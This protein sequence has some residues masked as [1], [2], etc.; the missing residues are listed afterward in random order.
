MARSVFC[1]VC[2]ALVMLTGLPAWAA[3]EGAKAAAAPA[4]FVIAGARKVVEASEPIVVRYALSQAASAGEARRIEW[5][6]AGADGRTISQGA[7]EATALPGEFSIPSKSPW[8]LGT[9]KVS[10]TISVKDDGAGA[11]ALEAKAIEEVVKPDGWK[12]A[13]Y[14]RY[15]DEL[16]KKMREKFEPLAFEF[17]ELRDLKNVSA[18]ASALG[19]VGR[20]KLVRE[21]LD[22]DDVAKTARLRRY[23]GFLEFA[24]V[25]P[26]ARRE[27]KADVRGLV[28]GGLVA[29]DFRLEMTT[30]Q[31]LAEKLL[32]VQP[33]I[34]KDMKGQVL[35]P[36]PK[37]SDGLPPIPPPPQ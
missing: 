11:A 34:V 15:L 18:S 6:V 31:W 35:W 30:N 33:E 9:L 26:W 10:A 23:E 27:K 21:K 37:P 29:L 1:A 14:Q 24:A 25:D 4:A 7:A 8:P 17:P 19:G 3:D 28:E 5:T 36:E 2:A 16:Q 22:I 12:E 13:T 32:V 20:F